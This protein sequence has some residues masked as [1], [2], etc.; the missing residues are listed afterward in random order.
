[1]LSSRTTPDS[2]SR[3][4]NIFTVGRLGLGVPLQ[5]AFSG[6]SSPAAPTDGTVGAAQSPAAPAVPFVGAAATSRPCR[7]T[8]GAA[9]SPAAPTD[10]A[11]INSSHYFFH[12]GTHSS[13]QKRLRGLRL[14]LKITLLMG[15]LISNPLVERL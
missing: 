10:G 9:E 2:Y 1:M 7:S 12:L 13:T 5:W 3:N 14:L 4:G 11:R 6:P 8:V 15:G